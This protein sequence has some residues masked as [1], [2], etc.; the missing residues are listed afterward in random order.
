[1]PFGELMLH[2]DFEVG[3]LSAVTSVLIVVIPYSSPCASFTA[4]FVAISGRQWLNH[5]TEPERGS[6]IDPIQIRKLKVDRM[7]S[8]CFSVIMDCT[9]LTLQVALVLLGSGLSYC[10]FFLYQII[11]GVVIGF[12]SFCH[13]LTPSV[14][15]RGENFQGLSLPDL[16]YLRPS[17][18]G[19]SIAPGELALSSSSYQASSQ[20]SQSERWRSLVAHVDPRSGPRLYRLG[21][22]EAD[23]IGRAQGYRRI[24]TRDCLVCGHKIRPSHDTL[25]ECFDERS[26][27]LFSSPD[28]ETMSP[29]A[30]RPSPMPPFNTNVLE[31]SPMQQFPRRSLR[32]TVLSIHDATS[33]TESSSL[34]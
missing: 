10:L 18:L 13:F 34:C 2:E 11:A 24:R 27:P 12:T 6:S 19:S 8:W 32:S 25:L 17:P 9:P 30:Q 26:V 31:M 33:A 14:A 23:L 5:C 22:G 28:I 21:V 1:M 29:L 4:A 7:D 3:L 20:S 16:T 15:L